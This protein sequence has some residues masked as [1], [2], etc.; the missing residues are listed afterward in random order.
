MDNA[1][2]HLHPDDFNPLEKHRKKEEM[3]RRAMGCTGSREVKECLREQENQ[4]SLSFF[5]HA[6]EPEYLRCSKFR[7]DTGAWWRGPPPV[8][9]GA[10]ARRI[11]MGG[12]EGGLFG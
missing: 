7:K 9:P 10:P 3:Q 2:V 1:R 6:M 11:Y 5:A 12:D 8:P 4:T